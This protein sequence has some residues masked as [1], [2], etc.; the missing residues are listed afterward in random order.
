MKI[1]LN[2][3]VVKCLIFCVLAISLATL[4]LALVI[5]LLNWSNGVGTNLRFDWVSA[6]CSFLSFLGSLFLG[7]VAIAQN[8]TANR[9]N[10][11]LAQINKDQLE[12]SIISQD[13][14]Q[15]KFCNKQIVE[16]DT[17][18]FKLKFIDRRDIPIKEIL[19]S[20]MR[21]IP[22]SE[23]FKVAD[24]KKPI[25]VQKDLLPIMVEYTPYHEKD[26]VESDG[27]YFA[28][29]PVNTDWFQENKYCRLEFNLD[30]ISTAKA[31]T[32]YR[33]R[34][35]LQRADGINKQKNRRY[36]EVYHQFYEYVDILS[37]NKYYKTIDK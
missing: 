29:I 37:E 34:L 26:G 15:I 2:T 5:N 21:I 24:G 6:G 36:P 25:V 8:D 23:M 9:Q 22:Y 30:A 1:R 7:I 3:R 27:F 31:V 13:Y 12:S 4:A 35:L 18:F 10:E 17:N 28:N 20:N 32:R 11:K 14:P 16:L 33:Y 19:V